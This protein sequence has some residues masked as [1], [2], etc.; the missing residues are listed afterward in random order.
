MSKQKAVKPA[1]AAKSKLTDAEKN[2]P[3]AI[4]NKIAAEAPP[5]VFKSWAARD[6]WF[7]DKYEAI[8]Q[9]EQ[10]AASARAAQNSQKDVYVPVINAGNKGMGRNLPVDVSVP[11][12]GKRSP[13]R[14][15]K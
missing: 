6:V 5:E 9:K 7:R 8:K 10:M 12:K 14:K 3:D 4:W 2:M 11:P 1:G 15:T 13:R